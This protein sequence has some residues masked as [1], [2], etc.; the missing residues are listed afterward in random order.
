MDIY[1]WKSQLCLAAGVGIC[2][3]MV[4]RH[5]NSNGSTKKMK[6]MFSRAR[7]ALDEVDKKG[8][9]KRTAAGFRNKIKPGG[10][11]APEAGRYHLYIALGCPWA[12]GT[13]TALRLKGLDKVIGV[14]IV[15]PTWAR[16]RPNDPD[17]DHKGWQFKAP[18]DPPVS[19]ATGYGSFECDDALVPDTV[20]GCAFVR[21]L[22]ELAEDKT[23]KYSTPLLWCKKENTIVC[24]ESMDI[25]K[26]FDSAFDDLCEHPERKL[27]PL[28]TLDA[29]NALNDFIYP[30]INNGVY[31]CGFAQSQE[32]YD[33]AVSQ[34]FS[35]LDRVEEQ[36]NLG[37]HSF[38]TGND[39]TW[40]DLRLYNTL[41]RF[42]CVYITYFKTNSKRIADYPHLLSYMRRCYAIKEVR[43]TTNL[44]HIMMHY[45]TSHPRYNPYA[46]I[47]ESKGPSLEINGEM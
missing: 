18:G 24:N 43:E 32:A 9:F 38:L 6:K 33:S 15:H 20:N 37:P 4:F 19:S 31:R 47:P 30:T 42:D 16:S 3:A 41:V 21:D 39:F 5:R 8:E 40:I 29:A 35:S 14:S 10:R 34:L 1:T 25:L 28:D 36:L 2:A 22:Y 11:F 26:M 13:L 23:G 46:V 7:T 44:R 27:F 45:F 12:N 17:D